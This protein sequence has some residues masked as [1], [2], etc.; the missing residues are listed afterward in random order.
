MALIFRAV[1]LVSICMFLLAVPSSLR[2]DGEPARKGIPFFG[3]VVAA[4]VSDGTATIK[5]GKI[6]GFAEAATTEYRINPESMLARLHQG[7]DIRATARP[8]ETSLDHVV[9]VSHAKATSSATGG[10]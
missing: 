10:R 6:P 8:G 2:G 7:D 9:V 4:Q 5:H 3:R 1:R